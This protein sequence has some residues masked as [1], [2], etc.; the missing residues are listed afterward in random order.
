MIRKKTTVTFFN[1]LNLKVFNLLSDFLILKVKKN[2][3]I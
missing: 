3:F 2:K 1:Y